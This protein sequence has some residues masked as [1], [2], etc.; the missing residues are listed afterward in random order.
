MA[1]NVKETKRNEISK[2]VLA[3]MNLVLPKDFG[4][5]MLN[6][7]NEYKSNNQLDFPKGY[8]V[9]N[10]IKSA[11]VQLSDPKFQG[12]TQQSVANAL[13]NMCTLGLNP[14]RNQ[15]YF[16]KMGNNLVML[17]SYFGKVTALK[18][19]DGV[20]DVVADVLYEDTDYDLSVNEFGLE[21]IKITK[22]CPLQNRKQDKIVGAWACIYL[23]K[24]KFMY[25]KY[26]TIMTIEDIRNVW[27]MGS[28]GGKSKAHTNFTNEMAKKSVINRC[29]KMFVNT[30]TDDRYFVDAIIQSTNDEYKYEGANDEVFYNKEYNDK[31]MKS[32]KIEENRIIVDVNDTVEEKVE[33]KNKK[34]TK[35]NIDDLANIDKMVN[36]KKELN[37]EKIEETKE[38][39]NNFDLIDSI[40]DIQF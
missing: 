34:E 35:N 32:K 10:A 19:I 2:E 20:I 21:E 1:E 27:G 17:P 31:E 6:T 40:G 24:G 37:K 26:Y 36:E 18:R 30:L 29:I 3:Q 28:S 22:P 12:C 39:S 16:I 23:E 4:D 11:W 33:Q 7:M 13:I 15:C 14:S 25:D 8:P 38:D 9:G 5:V